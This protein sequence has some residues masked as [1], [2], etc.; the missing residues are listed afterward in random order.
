MMKMN[1]LSV[2]CVLLLLIS[3]T[4][5]GYG[6]DGNLDSAGFQNLFLDIRDGVSDY[7]DY[8]FEGGTPGAPLSARLSGWDSDN[9][10][11]SAYGDY[12]ENFA[13]VSGNPALYNSDG[14]TM[15]HTPATNW[16]SNS[17]GWFKPFNTGVYN[18]QGTTNAHG[19]WSDGINDE[20][21]FT[22]E[23]RVALGD[24]A[25]TDGIFM[26]FDVTDA[27]DAWIRINEQQVQFGTHGWV[28]APTNTELMNTYRIAVLGVNP[29]DPTQVMGSLWQ[30]ND[31]LFD[32]VQIGTV[33][34]VSA[35]SYL[36]GMVDFGTG[37]Y[38][39]STETDYVRWDVMGAW[40]PV[41][42]PATM[43]LLGLGGLAMARRRQSK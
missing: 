39:G 22:V 33:G 10:R 23:W 26:Q 42:E 16:G 3:G 34:T 18:P 11:F 29:S 9:N 32:A 37:L 30:N 38:Y 14:T 19:I 6:I 20:D 36:W 40:A 24:H 7:W 2:M 27:R 28:T 8:S 35:S 1:H 4:A 21:G 15:S 25:G 13:G 17:T 41:P 12:L 31:L 43:L 5:F